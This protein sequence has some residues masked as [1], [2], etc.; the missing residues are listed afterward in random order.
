MAARPFP[1]FWAA[2]REA[3]ASRLYGGIHFRP[4]N[5]NGLKQGACIGAHTV[6]LRTLP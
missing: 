3:A 5:D 6:A 4:A 2:A 1:S